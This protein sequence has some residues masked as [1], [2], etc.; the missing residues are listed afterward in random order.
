[1]K[2]IWTFVDTPAKLA[3][4]EKLGVK[5]ISEQEFMRMIAYKESAI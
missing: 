1:M 2:R 5:I 4:A 3:K